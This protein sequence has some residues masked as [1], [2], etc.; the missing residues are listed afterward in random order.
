MSD[1]EE[2]PDFTSRETQDRMEAALRGAR[3]V[4]HKEMKDISP[5][6]PAVAPKRKKRPS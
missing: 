4:G 2:K 6:R 3:D 5:K 1:K